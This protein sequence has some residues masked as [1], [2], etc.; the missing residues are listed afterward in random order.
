MWMGRMRSSFPSSAYLFV[1]VLLVGNEVWAQ[2]P[3]TSIPALKIPAAASIFSGEQE[4]ILGDIEAEL[5]ESNYRAVRDDGLAAHLNA[6]AGRILSQF[7]HDQVRIRIIMI[8]TPEADS[9]SIG[10]DRIYISR[11]MITLLKNDD[12]L[13]GLLGHELSHILMHQNAIIVSQLFHGILGINAVRDRR[14][15]ADTFTRLFDSIDRNPKMLGKAAQIMERQ[16]TIYQYEA[17]RVALYASA[18]AGFSPQAF[19]NLFDR[20]AEINGRAG[21]LMTDFFAAPTSNKRR[22]REINKTLRQLPRP[23]RD[24]VP[25]SSIEFRTWQA[26]VISYPDLAGAIMV[27]N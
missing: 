24:I 19:V 10:P 2:Q 6:V 1:L 16:E 5:V 8:D 22:L 4:R 26:A 17:D 13:A 12:E 23:C 25:A 27:V 21:N 18:A 11:K 14:D 7:P 20:S 9:F 15:I 3:C